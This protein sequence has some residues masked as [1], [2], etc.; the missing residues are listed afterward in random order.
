LIWHGR[1]APG[2]ELKTKMFCRK[3]AQES[4]NKGT[5]VS[6]PAWVGLFEHF[7]PFRG[8]SDF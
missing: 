3:K 6:K 5:P 1:I 4:Q 7:V 2:G 8:H